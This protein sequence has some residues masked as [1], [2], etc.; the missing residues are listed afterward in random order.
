MHTFA[1]RSCLWAV[2]HQFA[3]PVYDRELKMWH[4][5]VQKSERDRAANS[6]VLQLD[7]LSYPLVIAFDGNLLW[8]LNTP[9]F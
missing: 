2:V 4:V 6:L 3:T 5:S 1:K 7:K 8:F 9:P